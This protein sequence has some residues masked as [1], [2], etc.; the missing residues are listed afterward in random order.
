M[1][2]LIAL[3]KFFKYESAK[4]KKLRFLMCNEL[5]LDI[6][7]NTHLTYLSKKVTAL[8]LSVHYCQIV[9]D[10][11]QAIQKAL[12]EAL[13]RSDLI[14]VTGGLGPTVDDLTRESVASA[15]GRIDLSDSHL[16]PLVNAL[17][18]GSPSFSNSQSN[19]IK[20]K[21]AHLSIMTE[22]RPPVLIVRALK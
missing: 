4:C 1:S 19:A 10:N 12:K 5:L 20:L 2:E 6:R 18:V 13:S 9:P 3:N 21:G 14:I 16:K 17:K 15:L 7:T 22:G 8:G 11:A